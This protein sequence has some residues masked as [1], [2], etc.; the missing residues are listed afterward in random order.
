M[1]KYLRPEA[2]PADWESLDEVQQDAFSSV[3]RTLG[4]AINNLSDESASYRYGSEKLHS[5]VSFERASRTLFISGARG[6]GKTTVLVTLIRSSIEGSLKGLDN[7]NLKDG[8]KKMKDHVVWL[9]PLDMEPLPKNSNL[10][11]SILARID[12]AIRIESSKQ[13]GMTFDE[14]DRY[15]PRQLFEPSRDYH[16]SMLKLQRL[17]TDIA[18]AWD[19]NIDA[20]EGHLDPDSFALET[21]RS[22]QS[23][24]LI[25]SKFHQEIELLIF[26]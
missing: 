15:R 9:E 6:T 25:N 7:G 4:E 8:I 16:D 26:S 20:R 10:L 13:I 23:R 12:A 2:R 18:I 17:Q 3:V 5:L 11:G 1:Q 24:L 22:E 14:G 19:G 21:M